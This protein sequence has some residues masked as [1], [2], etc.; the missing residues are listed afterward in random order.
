MQVLIEFS[1]LSYIPKSNVNIIV[2]YEA[3]EMIMLFFKD[4]YS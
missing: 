4:L 1:L 2:V 3:F